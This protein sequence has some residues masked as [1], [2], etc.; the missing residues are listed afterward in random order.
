MFLAVCGTFAIHR[1]IVRRES[2]HRLENDSTTALVSNVQTNSPVF[3]ADKIAVKPNIESNVIGGD[4]EESETVFE[5]T[6]DIL[7]KLESKYN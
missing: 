5:S 1:D 2:K 6:D 4:I 3:D 7:N